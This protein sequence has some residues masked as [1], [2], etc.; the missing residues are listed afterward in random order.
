MTVTYLSRPHEGGGRSGLPPCLNVLHALVVVSTVNN[1]EENDLVKTMTKL[2]DEKSKEL[3]SPLL[4]E[5]DLPFADESPEK[6]VR[7]RS[8]LNKENIPGSPK[9]YR[10]PSLHKNQYLLPKLSTF[11]NKESKAKTDKE[12][13]EDSTMTA[14]ESTPDN[15]KNLSNQDVSMT[16]KK[17]NINVTL[18]PANI[19]LKRSESLNK[20]ERT[21]SP[22]TIK[23][24][25]SESLNKTGDKVKRSDSLTKTEKTESNI[26][27][28]RETNSARRTNKEFA[29]LKRKNGMPERSI[30]RRHTVGGTKDPD[31]VTWWDN[32]NQVEDSNVSESAKE[33][34]LRTS[35]PDLSTSRR[36]RLFLQVNLIT[37][38]D[39]VATLRQHLIGSRPQSFPEATVYKLPLESHV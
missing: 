31:K 33:K 3:S 29:K 18:S 2:Y 10:N 22:L 17:I 26:S 6:L 20:P 24:K 35:S 19:K 4:L 15:E 39:M 37:S 12:K 14:D 28:R 5:I 34:T 25:R 7:D 13:D 8:R 23:L 30:K 1:D 38:E 36:E 16:S 11:Q 9:L 32:R 21:S 27:K